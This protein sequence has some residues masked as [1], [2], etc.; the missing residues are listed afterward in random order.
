MNDK[1]LK[2]KIEE[3][4]YQHSPYENRAWIT[5][6]DCPADILD[7]IRNEEYKKVYGRERPVASDCGCTMVDL[8]TNEGAAKK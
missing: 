6:D 7:A 5:D 1:Q 2:K 4:I 8:T 3:I